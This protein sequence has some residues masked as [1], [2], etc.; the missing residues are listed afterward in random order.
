MRQQHGQRCRDPALADEQL[1]QIPIPAFAMQGVSFCPSSCCQW[2]ACID[3]E[4]PSADVPQCHACLLCKEKGDNCAVYLGC[5]QT[6]GCSTRV[7]A[8]T[9]EVSRGR[10]AVALHLKQL[11]LHHL[12]TDIQAVHCCVQHGPRS[13]RHVLHM[14]NVACKDKGRGVC[15]A[16]ISPL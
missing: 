16:S 14:V 5:S 3:A 11:P 12:H 2:S 9:A 1:M 10:Y 15:W 4:Q 6:P 13:M 7:P 8:R